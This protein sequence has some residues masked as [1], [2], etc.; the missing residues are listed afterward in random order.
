[1]PRPLAFTL[2]LLVPSLHAAFPP[3]DEAAIQALK[4]GRK[5]EASAT[6]WGFDDKDATK[7]LQA[8]ID[9]GAKR[10]VVPN[11]GAPWIATGI[12]L[13]SG[14][15]IV[16]EKG[17]EV[18]AK[19]GE[20][21]GANASLFTAR[22]KQNIKLTGPGATLRM[23]KADYQ[24][25]DYKKAEWRHALAFWSCENVEIT[26]LSVIESGGDGLYL[27]CGS[28]AKPC[29][30]FVVRDVKFLR[31]HR[32]GISVICAERLLIENC[33]LSG[34]SGTAPQA[35]IDFEPNDADERL[36][37]CVMRHCTLEGNEGGAF[38]FALGKMRPT[39]KPVSI[40]IEDCRSSRDSQAVYI[41]L[42]PPVGVG[43]TIAFTKCRMADTT[44]GGV[45]LRNLHAGS[46]KLTFRQCEFVKLADTAASGAPVCFRSDTFGK[47]VGGVQFDDCV[48]EDTAQ[49]RPIAFANAGTLPM[50]DVTGRFTVKAGGETKTVM[51]DD[52]QIHEWF[53]S[54]IELVNLPV[55]ECDP[56]KLKPAWPQTGPTIFRAGT[57]KQR[58]DASWIVFAQKGQQ[59]LL[60][61]T[62]GAVGK[63]EKKLAQTSVLSPS[64]KVMA[65]KEAPGGQAFTAEETGAY[66]VLCEAGSNSVQ[67]HAPSAPA[68]AYAP[69]GAFSFIYPAGDQFFLVPAGTSEFAITIGG[70]GAE[71]VR[72]MIF[73]AAGKVE[74][75]E[76]DIDAPRQFHFKRTAS[77]GD[78]IWTLR[79]M[80]PARGVCED[81]QVLIEGIPPLL[82]ATPEAT[83][84]LREATPVMKPQY[85]IPPP[86]SVR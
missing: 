70:D 84:G 9:S 1:M 79:L 73:S 31:H 74:W 62:T 60:T 48:I 32:Q 19:R 54:Q 14:Q 36:V 64:G 8:A 15:E 30:D 55:I 86:F 61:I 28:D 29:S 17:V 4:E 45:L 11:V 41:S 26:G 24:G 63:T 25:A 21:K 3:R 34:T 46:A 68:C 52:K 43:G 23:W 49:R 80:K 35:G 76:D 37:D 58:H 6:W 85:S 40:M 33:T 42:H 5:T 65:L 67:L 81:Y 59:V 39:S 66:R 2:L 38:L 22:N 53:P 27:G 72:A 82:A 56:R 12:K 16:F 78:E 57:M 13:A 10:V 44:K 77:S 75:D 47:T 51:L 69:D 20:F 71:K 7:A 18:Q 50:R 83:I